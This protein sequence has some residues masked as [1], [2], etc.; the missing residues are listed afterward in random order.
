MPPEPFSLFLSAERAEGL[1]AWRSAQA[2]VVSL[3]LPVDEAGFYPAAFDRMLREARSADECLRSLVQDTERIASFVRE[4]F[5]PAGRRGLCVF[6]CANRGLFEA[7][8]LPEPFKMSLTV[9]DRPRMLPLEAVHGRYRRFLV[10]LAGEKRARLLEMHLG[11]AVEL[12]A[13]EGDMLGAE[14]PALAARTASLMQAR[15]AD[16]LV[17]G[18]AAESLPAL[19]QSLPSPLQD[20]LILEPLLGPD[21]PIEAVA[22][23]VRHNERAALKVRESVLVQR[24]L[25]EMKAGDAVAGLE[26]VAA[27]VQQGCVKRLLVR[28][29]WTKM[30]R[31]CPTCRRLSVDHRS[32][33]WCF[34]ATEA[35]LDLVAELVD[36]AVT[37][38]VEVFRVVHDPRFDGIGRIGAELAATAMK[39]PE[40]PTSRALRAR[41]ALKEGWTSPLRSRTA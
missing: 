34:R 10:L 24:F 32:C 31:C 41:F 28:D 17:V 30:G 22:E 19:A 1:G 25:D 23:R 15:K 6:S 11:E 3:H 38:G 27:A 16:R 2:D 5:S 35:V 9:S 21:R 26:T 4:Q 20:S 14:L 7:F 12:E 36:R 13:P 40:V 33:P 37:N 18:A 39:R 8:S 29:G